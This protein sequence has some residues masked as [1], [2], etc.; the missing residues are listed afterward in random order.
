MSF[1]LT[2]TLKK[3][4]GVIKDK[5]LGAGG[6]VVTGDA[7]KPHIQDALDE[8][9]YVTGDAATKWGAERIKNGHP[10]PFKLT[11][12]EVGNEGLQVQRRLGG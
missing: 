4:G 1:S 10:Q 3:A 11:Y 9:E 6:E 8:I 5:A 7:L 2:D 12:V